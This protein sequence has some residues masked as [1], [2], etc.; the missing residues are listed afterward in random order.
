MYSGQ[1]IKRGGDKT[2]SIDRNEWKFGIFL[3]VLSE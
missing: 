3:Q 1:L 2:V